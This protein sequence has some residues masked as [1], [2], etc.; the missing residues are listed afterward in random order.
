MTTVSV[1]IR[2][3]FSLS[4]MYPKLGSKKQTESQVKTLMK[5]FK[6]N[7]RPGPMEKHQLAKSL[8]ISKRAVEKRFTYMRSKKLRQELLQKSEY[9]AQ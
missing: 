8:N 2:E 6:A 5:G 7:P 3:I 1:C 4:E 9:N